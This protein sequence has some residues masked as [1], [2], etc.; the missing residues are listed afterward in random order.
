MKH[1]TTCIALACGLVLGLMPGVGAAQG[2]GDGGIALTFGL[3]QRFETTSDRDLTDAETTAG[4]DSSTQFSFALS[5]ETRTEA[6]SFDFATGL[7][8]T[9]EGRGPWDVQTGLRYAR[10]GANAALT[11]RAG[12]D[13]TDIAVLRDLSDFLD[14]DGVLV[15]PDDLDDLTGTGLRTTRTYGAGLRWGTAGPLELSADLG[16]RQLR[17]SAASSSLT[18]AD[19]TTL[20]LGMRMTLSPVATAQARVSQTRY[21][22]ADDAPQKTTQASLGLTFDR[23][24][25]A[26]RTQ[27][28]ATRADDG[29]L[30]W[31]LSLGRSLD[32]PGQTLAA[33]LGVTQD[34]NGDA[35]ITGAL[36]YDYALP[37]GQI[38]LRAAQGF[39]TGGAND[40][41]RNTTLQASYAQTLSPLSSLQVGFDFAR[42]LETSDA[43][44]TRSNLSA[45][46]GLQLTPDWQMSLGARHDMRD[47]GAAQAHA[48]SVFVTLNR[49]FSVRP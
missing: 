11:L 26:L 17:Y 32:L 16:L 18:D 5:D 29:T 10:T 40:G 30:S 36:S 21:D 23:P 38:R 3:N 9:E 43:T 31:G 39:V 28:S 46:Y 12:Y 6:L 4:R 7:R 35:Q 47:D 37:E 34:R 45:S 22:A 27:L 25:G 15:L 44:L 1:L 49:S 13:R 2:A 41:R 14:A 19:T 42:T 20:G 33:D 24:A 48:K 8:L